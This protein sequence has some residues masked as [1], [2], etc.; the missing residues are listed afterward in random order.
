MA[1]DRMIRAS[2][3]SSEKVNGWPIP[4]RFFWSQLWGYCDSH[5][6]GRR[7]P[8]LIVADTFPIDE[9]V[10][11]QNVERWMQALE[12]AG[13]IEVYDVAG[14][15]YFECV[16]WDEH[17]DIKYRKRTD[18]PDRFGT[19]PTSAKSS[20][21]VQKV[22]EQGEGEGEIEGEIERE[23]ESTEDGAWPPLFCSSH[24]NGTTGKCGPCGDVRRARAAWEKANTPKP[25][26]TV[27]GIVTDPDCQKHPG[28][29]L[30]GCDRCAEEAV[31]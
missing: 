5:G 31:A 2:M 15:R 30:R 23:G 14:K 13:V 21:K 27:P 8:R 19:I 12:T 28:R 3:R 1:E 6:R 11:A 18:I 7:D 25:K 22:S 9:E 16:N 17:Q 24:P 29:P 10:S 20:R 4:L 26:P